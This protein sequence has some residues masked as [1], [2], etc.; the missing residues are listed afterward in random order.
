MEDL[1][2]PEE[3]EKEKM[4]KEINYEFRE[5]GSGRPTKKE[6]RFID[7]LKKLKY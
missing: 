4:K 1:T 6:R 2:P 7:R 5:R 3:Y